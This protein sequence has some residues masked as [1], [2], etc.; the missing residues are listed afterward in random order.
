MN[1]LII[2]SICWLNKWKKKLILLAYFSYL[3]CYSLVQ[4][5][6]QRLITINLYR[7]IL[8]YKFSPLNRT[9]WIRNRTPNHVLMIALSHTM[10]RYMTLDNPIVTYG[11]MCSLSYD[12][13]C[14][15]IK[16][17]CFDTCHNWISQCHVTFLPLCH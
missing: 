8:R 1:Y 10:V 9:F 11:K 7:K 3:P 16:K 13:L 15:F 6:H 17:I 14:F 4:S 2:Y 5:F 12:L